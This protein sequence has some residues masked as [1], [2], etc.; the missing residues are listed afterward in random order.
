MKN[1]LNTGT[2]GFIGAYLCKWSR[3]ASDAEDLFRILNFEPT[4]NRKYITAKMWLVDLSIAL[5][6]V[7]FGKWEYVSE[8]YQGKSSRYLELQSERPKQ[9]NKRLM[10]EY[11]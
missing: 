10:G 3:G 8:H 5:R 11:W 7:F 2:N 9:V 6:Q 1:I 4:V